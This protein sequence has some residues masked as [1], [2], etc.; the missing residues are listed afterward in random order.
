MYVFD[1][2]NKL[3]PLVQAGEVLAE[4]VATREEE[5]AG[6]CAYH[7]IS[8]SSRVLYYSAWLKFST[9]V[10]VDFGNVPL[11]WEYLNQVLI[12]FKMYDEMTIFSSTMAFDTPWPWLPL[13]QSKI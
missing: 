7:L 1:Y 10:Q 13:D 3:I 5:A 9:Q 12:V 4:A 11:E 6:Y 2:E 8:V